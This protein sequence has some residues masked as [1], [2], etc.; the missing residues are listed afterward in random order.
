MNVI[1]DP[2]DGWGNL[3][4][5]KKDPNKQES[6]Y[7]SR[8]LQRLIDWLSTAQLITNYFDNQFEDFFKKR[9]QNSLIPASKM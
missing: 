3:S 1:S 7:N 9:N 6:Y 8:E 2:F 5:D 4:R